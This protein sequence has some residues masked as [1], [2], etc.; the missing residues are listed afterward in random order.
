MRKR[1][2]SAKKKLYLFFR[3]N[4]EKNHPSILKKKAEQDSVADL[5]KYK[6]ERKTRAKRRRVNE[7]L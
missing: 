1:R 7:T 2:S 3:T 6:K 4:R 5:K